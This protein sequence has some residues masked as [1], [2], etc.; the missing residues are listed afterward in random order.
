MNRRLLTRAAA[1]GVLLLTMQVHGYGQGRGAAPANQTPPTGKAAAP[2]DPTGNWVSLI[3]N[4]WRFRMVPPAKGDYASIPIS[5][6]GK[7]V[8]DA[9]DPAEDERT[10]NQCKHYGAASLM[11]QPTRLRV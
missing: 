4:N 6:A 7:K 1:L 5:A 9:W 11:Y 8:A 2:F 10:G 3:T